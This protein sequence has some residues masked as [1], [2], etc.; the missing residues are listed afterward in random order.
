MKGIFYYI[1]NDTTGKQ[2]D[3]EEYNQYVSENVK[4]KGKKHFFYK[5]TEVF[6]LNLVVAMIIYIPFRF[7]NYSN[8]NY[9]ELYKYRNQLKIKT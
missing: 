9:I 6:L 1:Y 7:Y 4:I 5:Y 2:V 3:L 8:K